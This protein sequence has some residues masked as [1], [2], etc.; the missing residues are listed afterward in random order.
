LSEIIENKEK[1]SQRVKTL[2]IEEKQFSNEREK[3][4]SKV[5]NEKGV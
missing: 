2:D 3:L 1:L 4:L 5:D